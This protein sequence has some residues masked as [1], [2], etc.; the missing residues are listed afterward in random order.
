MLRDPAPAEIAVFLRRI[1]T[2]AILGV[3]ISGRLSHHVAHGAGEIRYRIVPIQSDGDLNP[4]PA[5][6]AGSGRGAGAG[7]V[8]VRRICGWMSP[9]IVDDPSSKVPALWLQEGVNPMRSP[10]S[11][12]ATQASSRRWIAASSRR[13]RRSR[14]DRSSARPNNR[15]PHQG[16]PG[17][18]VPTARVPTARRQAPGT[19]RGEIDVHDLRVDLKH[20][21]IAD[22]VRR[23]IRHVDLEHVA[24]VFSAHFPGA[25]GTA[26]STP[27][28]CPLR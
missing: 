19:E 11:V 6:L 27:C 22:A 7:L 25:A 17:R 12:P 21:E 26:D 28:R 10:R 4:G 20:I 24:G 8:D 3:G 9:S 1:H 14:I 23:E 13:V 16:A 18:A 15:K 5:F 2:I